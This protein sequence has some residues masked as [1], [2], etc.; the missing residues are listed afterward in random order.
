MTDDLRQDFP[1]K[2][3]TIALR[4]GVGL[5]AALMAL[6]AV[7]GAG[8]TTGVGGGPVAE[9]VLGSGSDTTQFMMGALDNLYQF[10]PGCAQIPTGATPPNGGAA[11]FDFSCQAPDPAGT[12]TTENY[13]HD[14]VAQAYFLGSSNGIKQLCTQ[15]QTNVAHIDY[16]RSS[17][18]P[19][20]TDCSGLHFVAYARDAISWEAYNVT[21]SGI[22]T[23]NNTSGVCAGTG[24]TTKKFCLTQQQLKYI[25]LGGDPADSG[26][27]GGCPLNWSEFGG[28][29][30]AIDPY[31]PQPGSGTRSTWDGFLGGSSDACINA[32]GTTYATSHIV[33]ENSNTAVVANADQAGAIFPFSYGVW[34]TQVKGK[35]GAVL[36]LVDKI[37]PTATTIGNLTFPYGRFLFNV[38]NAAT[39]SD[40]TSR[41][42]GEEG[43]LCKTAANHGTNPQTGNNYSTDIQA[44]I[45]ASG[46]VPMPSGTIG[47][48]D[49]NQDYCRLTVTP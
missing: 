10:S 30:V 17:R 14:Q 3:G 7:S 18:A 20:T 21:G 22:A 31:T 11:W 35:N 38:F 34:S 45:K 46:F 5:G 6:S 25:F 15:G 29:S 47:G 26:N 4:A 39:A 36:G 24:G 13:Q 1:M 28:A 37:A 42:V 33:P 16:A 8:A 40:G 48:G 32:R 44:A 49:N 19:K 41:Y 9:S 12:V 27:P 23:M 43:W 2:R